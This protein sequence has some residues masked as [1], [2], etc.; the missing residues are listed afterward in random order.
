MLRADETKLAHLVEVGE[1]LDLLVLL[2]KEHLDEE[3]LS[4][5]L[6]QIP[7]ILSVFGSLNWN[8]EASVLCNVDLVG[9]V[10]VDGQSSRLNVC[11]AEFAEAAFP[12]RP[13]LLPDL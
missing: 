2:F 9:D 12:C 3:H 13:V 8:V 11:L 1:A 4:L 6:N 7:T 5:L 10:G